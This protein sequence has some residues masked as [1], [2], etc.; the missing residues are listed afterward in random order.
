MRTPISYYGGKQNMLQHIIPLIPKHEIYVEPFVGGGAVF[1]AKKP[2]YLEAINDINGNVINFY[3][4]LQKKFKS[5]QREIKNSLHSELLYKEAREIYHN[6]K[7]H[8]P[9]KRAWAFWYMANFSYANTLDGGWKWDNGTKG[10]HMGR[11]IVIRKNEFLE[12]YTKRI[13]S[14]QISC[15]DALK[16]IDERNQPNAFFY[17]DPPYPGSDQGHY[18]GY[19]LEHLIKLLDKCVQIKGKFMLSCYDLPIIREYAKKH[20]WIIKTF[21]MRL[22]APRQND[23]RKTEILVMNYIS[24]PLQAELNF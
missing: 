14:V 10:S 18:E 4:V 23:R 9:I 17:L 8:S 13:E 11:Y 3:R 19:T 1:W 6:P 2:C 24:E 5:L 12:F 7:E 15:R 20:G 21:D 16:V 22:S